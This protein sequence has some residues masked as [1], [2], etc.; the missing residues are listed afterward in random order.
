[1]E[2]LCALL[3][4]FFLWL[5]VY[6]W[7]RKSIAR[8]RQVAGELLCAAGS[9][10]PRRWTFFVCL[11]LAL[12][13]HTCN[14][15]S[16]GHPTLGSQFGLAGLFAVV[17]LLGIPATRN[18]TIEVRQR[19]VF[20]SRTGDRILPGRLHF[21]PWNQITVCHWVRKGYGTVSKFDSTFGR[22]RIAQDT[23]PPEQKPGVTAAI[24]QFVPIYDYDSAPLTKPDETRRENNLNSWR[25][26]DP[27]RFQ[28]D[29]QTLL[30]LVIVVACAANVFGLR[31]RSP[32]FQA[33]RKLG[34]FDPKI[35]YNGRGEVFELDFSTCANKPTDNDL[36]YLEPL[37]ELRIL[38]LS[39]AAIT[40]AGLLHLKKLKKLNAVNLANTGVTD[41]GMADL[42]RALPK[43]NIGKQVLWIP[44]NAVPLAPT[45][46]KG[47]RR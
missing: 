4:G 36:T 39:G 44:P 5:L 9:T 10:R 40:D 31:Y 38:D 6:Q 29:L 32:E 1:M 20:Y 33:M 21:V 8:W 35:Q 18:V 45:P 41:Q 16:R 37:T 47:K 17:L 11:S 3:T 19:G 23:I 43:A 15:I 26:L 42:R 13:G 12:A 24:G 28:F 34:A 46:P 14:A 2:L 30:L 22:L 25:E 7:R 27:P